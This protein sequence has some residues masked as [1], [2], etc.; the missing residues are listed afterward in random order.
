MCPFSVTPLE[1]SGSLWF[2]EVLFQNLV[3]YIGSSLLRIVK[4]NKWLINNLHTSH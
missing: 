2:V 4:P 1:N 3:S